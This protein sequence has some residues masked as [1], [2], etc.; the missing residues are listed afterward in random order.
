MN[1]K[2]HLRISWATGDANTNLHFLLSLSKAL[3]HIL[4]VLLSR[5]VIT[6]LSH[7]VEVLTLK[8]FLLLSQCGTKECR[9]K[10]ALLSSSPFP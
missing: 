10:M 6:Y 5:L 7:S 8:H 1:T 3:C 9:G 4:I 2:R